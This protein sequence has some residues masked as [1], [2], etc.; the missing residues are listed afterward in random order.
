MTD[1][2][3]IET[4]ATG[5]DPR[6]LRRVRWGTVVNLL[7]VSAPYAGFLYSIVKDGDHVWLIFVLVVILATPLVA[8]FLFVLFRVRAGLTRDGMT[9]A[10]SSSTALLGILTALTALYLYL[11]VEVLREGQLRSE[12]LLLLLP[13][14]CVLLMTPAWIVRMSAKQAYTSLWPT[15]KP[16]RVV[17]EAAGLLLVFVFFIGLAGASLPEMVSH[18]RPAN[19]ASALGSLRTINTAAIAYESTYA[20][21]FPPSLGVLGPGNPETCSAADLIESVLAGGKKTG[22]LFVYT[23]GPKVEKP[24]KGCPP[25]AKSYTVTARPQEFGKTGHRNFFT[26]ETGVIRVTSENRAATVKDPPI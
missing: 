1:A 8:P 14:A 11:A 25:G 16:R 6:L 18:R 5:S 24:A 22:Y 2:P 17:L 4:P 12:F 13:L 19:E 21:G 9:L 7:M 26:D 3:T 20:N 10:M 23:P 15:E